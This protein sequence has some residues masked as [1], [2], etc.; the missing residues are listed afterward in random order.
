MLHI[1]CIRIQQYI[2]LV[3]NKTTT[4][5]KKN[6]HDDEIEICMYKIMN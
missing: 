4:P 5:L 3:S 6:V 2:T 1:I